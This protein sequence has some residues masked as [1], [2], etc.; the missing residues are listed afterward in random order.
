[1][2]ALSKFLLC[3]GP[4]EDQVGVYLA[5][6]DLFEVTLTVKTVYTCS[7]KLKILEFLFF[8]PLKKGK[9]ANKYD[10]ITVGG[11]L[12]LGLIEL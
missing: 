12:K 4:L 2:S 6:S 10:L 9:F 11:C 7:L 5:A 3:L 8:L 1:M